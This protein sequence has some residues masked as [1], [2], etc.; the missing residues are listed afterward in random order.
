MALSSLLFSVYNIIS[1]YV[2]SFADFWT[3]FA[4]TRI[5]TFIAALV[6]MFW[7][8]NDL[9][10]STKQHGKTFLLGASASG[11][12]D[13]IGT[14]LITIA[15]AY[16]SVTLASTLALIQ[17]LFVLVFTIFLSHFFPAILKEETGISVIGHKLFAIA[18]MIIGV[19]LI[20]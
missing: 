11:I 18:L 8:F 19:L 13:V 5:G 16:G 9:M 15:F 4:Y 6:F 7:R 14:W 20:T 17:P 2:L 12:L 10:W 3:V 1:K